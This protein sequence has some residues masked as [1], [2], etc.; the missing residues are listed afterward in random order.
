MI[1]WCLRKILPCEVFN[2]CAAAI[3]LCYLSQVLLCCASEPTGSQSLI[4]E[5]CWRKPCTCR[6]LQFRHACYLPIFSPL[7]FKPV[8]YLSVYS[9]FSEQSVLKFFIIDI[10]GAGYSA[11]IFIALCPVLILH[12]HK[13][14]DGKYSSGSGNLQFPGLFLWCSTQRAVQSLA[15]VVLWLIIIFHLF[16]TLKNMQMT[17]W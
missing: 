9:Y 14:C 1:Y 12:L 13:S 2:F 6:E 11:N 15:Q 16:S 7:L 5:I 8:F 10:S 3:Q 4:L 17:S